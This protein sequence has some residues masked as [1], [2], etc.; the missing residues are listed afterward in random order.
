M[1]IFLCLHSLY[2]RRHMQNVTFLRIL[3]PRVSSRGL[4]WE[5][6]YKLM[7]S[8]KFLHANFVGSRLKHF[9]SYVNK[10]LFRPIQET[11]AN[12]TLR[13]RLS[14]LSATQTLQRWQ[15]RIER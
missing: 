12:D 10:V 13:T 6:M 2:T 4:Y 3:F 1:G 5:N 9:A 15:Q 7:S 11:K 8:V 14:I